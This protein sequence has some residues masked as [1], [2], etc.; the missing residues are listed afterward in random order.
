[1]NTGFANSSGA[2][3]PADHPDHEK[4]EVTVTVNE[5][6]VK[7][8]DNTATGAQIKAEAIKQGVHIQQNFV[9]Q[10][11]LPNGMSRVVGDSDVVHLREHLRFTAIAPD[12]NS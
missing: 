8:Y 1:M 3:Q 6:P 4:H 9:L 12:D 7:L 10:E 11:E 5:Q 2:Q